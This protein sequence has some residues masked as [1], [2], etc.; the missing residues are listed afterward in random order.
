MAN[1][2]RERILL[3]WILKIHELFVI[4]ETKEY[5]REVRQ[6]LPVNHSEAL[7]CTFLHWAVVCTG[8]H[9]AHAAYA[10]HVTIALTGF[11]LFHMIRKT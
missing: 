3:I 9:W 2:L 1:H 7:K 4:I 5:G 11:S 8:G 6:F 10:Y